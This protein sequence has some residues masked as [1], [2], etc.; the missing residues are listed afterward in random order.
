M[1]KIDIEKLK[2]TCESS[3]SMALAAI[4][5]GLHQNTLRRHAIKAGCYHPNKSGKGLTKEQEPK[6]PLEEILKGM[7]P[8]YQTNK[9]RKRLIKAGIKKKQCETCGNIGQWMGKPLTIEL[10]HID[11]DRSNHRIEN[12]RMLCPNCHSQTDTFRSKNRGHMVERET[13][14][15]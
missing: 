11:G 6:I 10:D 15:A 4:K 1:K 3:G 9:L 14:Q 13:L 12:L 8:Y 2:Q 5:L 7:H